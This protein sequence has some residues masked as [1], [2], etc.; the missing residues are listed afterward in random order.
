MVNAEVYPCVQVLQ[1][2]WTQEIQENTNFFV[3][4]SFS[5][6]IINDSPSMKQNLLST[7]VAAYV[8]QGLSWDMLGTCRRS[9]GESMQT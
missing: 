5:D 3:Q 1:S 9:W 2:N 8:T 4:L 6:E 7:Q